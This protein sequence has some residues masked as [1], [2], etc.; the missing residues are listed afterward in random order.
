MS[1]CVKCGN[2][3]VDVF[4]AKCGTK[5]PGKG[6]SDTASNASA[7]STAPVAASTTSSSSAPGYDWFNNCLTQPPWWIWWLYFMSWVFVLA[8]VAGAP[9]FVDNSDPNF[10]LKVTLNQSF[11]SAKSNSALSYSDANFASVFGLPE[12]EGT[13]RAGTASLIFALFCL[14]W[15]CIFQWKRARGQDTE[16]YRKWVINWSIAALPFILV[17]IVFFGGWCFSSYTNQIDST[18]KLDAGFA[19]CIVAFVF[20]AGSAFFIYTKPA[21]G[22]QLN[23][24]QMQN[25]KQ[26]TTAATP[27]SPANTTNTTAVE[28]TG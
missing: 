25:M 8:S 22:V 12:C 23:Q 1:F 5:Q 27:A 17:P 7:G 11:Y 19:L 28:G 24:L 21:G 10:I 9:W 14:T 18:A 20:T 26:N 6:G 15:I 2:P 4:C 13:G 16:K 3:N